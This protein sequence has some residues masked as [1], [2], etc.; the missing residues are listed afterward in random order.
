M[1]PERIAQVLAG[2]A[3]LV[4]LAVAGRYDFFRDELYFI[5]CGRHPAFGYA[6]HP[7]VIPLLAAAT[8]VFGPHLVVLRLVSALVAAATVLVTCALARR[9][10][11]ESYGVALA[12]AAVT[13]APMYLGMFTVLNTTTFEPIA[14]TLVA[15]LAA[16]AVLDD[17]PSAWILAGL[18]SGVALETK[19]LIPSYVGPLAVAL[20]LTGH[21]RALLRRQLLAGVVLAGVLAA[22]SLIWQ[23]THGLPFRDLVRAGAAGKNVVLPPLAFVANQIQVMNLFLAPIWVAGAVAPFVDRRFARWRFVSLAFLLTFALMIA[24]HAKDYYLAPAYASVF[25]LGGAAVEAWVRSRALRAAHLAAAVGLS[26]VAAP[27]AMPI[28]DPPVLV[29]YTSAIRART[30]PTETWKQSALPQEFAD[31]LGW[32]EYV[33]QVAQ[34]FRQLSAE[35]QRR[36]ALLTSN[37]GEA[38]A[39]DFYGPAE[40]LPPAI[41][42]HNQYWFWGPRGHDGSV[43]LR[44]NGDEELWRPRCDTLT[45]AGRFGSPLVMPYENDAPIL[46][47]RGLKTPLPEL[48][49]KF[50]HIE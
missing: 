6:D 26:V 40:G 17:E 30:T 8:Q 16:R 34:V 5:I 28:L 25:A 45:V 50:K 7:P 1:K 32:R 14:W 24:M 31:M 9:A 22:P 18:V 13:I 43:V 27:L 19:Y 46:L 47:C 10:G 11:A 38:A 15:L 21:A 37:Y 41:S 48:W 3:F 20:V 44:I 4:H 33:Q 35:D 42:G 36:A 2:L 49:D 29:A 39:I 23:L 12:G